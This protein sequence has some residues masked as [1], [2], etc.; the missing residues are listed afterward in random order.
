MK[1]PAAS[2]RNLLSFIAL[3]LLLS[4]CNADLRLPDNV[5]IKVQMSFVTYHERVSAT[6]SGNMVR[7]DWGGFT[8]GDTSAGASL[9]GSIDV[10]PPL[11]VEFPIQENLYPG[12]WNITIRAFEDNEVF[13]EITCENLDIGNEII[14]F[15]VNTVQIFENG[16]CN[17]QGAN[18]DPPAPPSR[19]VEATSIQVP[20]TAT[21]G[22]VITVPVGIRNHGDLEENVSVTLTYRPPTGGNPVP[23]ASAAEFIAALGSGSVNLDWDTSCLFQ[24]G[25]YLIEASVRIPNDSVANNS[26]SSVVQLSADRE[27]SVANLDGPAAIE[28]GAIGGAPY[29][30]E[31]VNGRSRAESDIDVTVADSFS[32]PGTVQQLWENP[33]DFACGERRQLYFVYFPSTL[34][35]APE[36]GSLAVSIGTAVPGDDP[37]DNSASITVDL[38]TP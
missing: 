23:I 2:C 18:I 10:V 34:I 28:L 7:T 8:T 3:P 5:S 29:S 17:A 9:P 16:V 21:I 14:Y 4:S 20:S 31:V 26:R 15:G 37:A 22:E 25:D 13:L 19:D 30:F 24:E 6:W 38:T 33:L 35:G 11:T 1:A 12:I 32:Q 36:Q 27:V